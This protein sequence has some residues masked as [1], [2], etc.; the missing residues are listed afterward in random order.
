MIDPNILRTQPELVRESQ[1]KRG[2]D[3]SLVDQW[4]EADIAARE[5]QR[6][7]DSLRNEQKILGKEIGPLQGA[8]K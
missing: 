1:T 6:A 2:E 3:A 7:F 4:L 5:G 8:L